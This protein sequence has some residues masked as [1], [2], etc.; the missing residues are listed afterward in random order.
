MT[1]KSTT[2]NIYDNHN[3]LGNNL[4]KPLSFEAYISTISYKLLISINIFL[5]FFY[6]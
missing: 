5:L 3:N 1:I 4:L 2:V 6:S